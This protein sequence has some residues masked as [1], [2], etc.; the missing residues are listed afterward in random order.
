MHTLIIG[1]S[2]TG[3]SALVK[4]IGSALREQSETVYGFNPTSEAGYSRRDSF[5]CVAA[6]W[7]T[8]DADVFAEKIETE[9]ASGKA[10]KRFLLI[11]ECH[12]FFRRAEGRQALWIATRGR[13]FGLN[14]IGATQR[15]AEIHPT[16]RAQCSTVYV[17]ACSLT[18][19]R[20]LSDEFGSREIA[21][22]V[23]LPVGSFLKIDRERNITE[24][25]VF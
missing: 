18:D 10:G 6:E 8:H 3:K 9:I 15:G 20:F 25:H 1:R 7:E 23:S 17:F 5:G 22:A 12:E 2:G 4:Q 19:A 13:H 11:D 14:I 24:G 21:D 16:F